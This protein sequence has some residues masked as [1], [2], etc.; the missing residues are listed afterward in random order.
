MGMIF[1]ILGAIPLAHAG[2]SIGLP[3][4]PISNGWSVLLAAFALILALKIRQWPPLI[5]KT[6]RSMAMLFLLL[7]MGWLLGDPIR[8]WLLLAIVIGFGWGLRKLIADVF[9]SGLLKL[10]HRPQTV[11]SGADFLGSI[12]SVKWR[13]VSL[14][15]EN[16]IPLDVP[17]RLMFTTAVTFLSSGNCPTKIRVFIPKAVRFQD[18]ID[19]IDKRLPAI[20][21]L[22]E[23]KASYEIDQT[24]P[25]I[26]SIR[27]N[28]LR[29]DDKERVR[30]SI[31][32]ALLSQEMRL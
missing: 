13:S 18:A 22:R 23:T 16:G 21:W 17:S 28:L 19:C 15:Q 4:W 6:M 9:A 30:K 29:F 24:N 10:N 8:N 5:Q 7:G 32:E 20:P 1:F 25:N 27:L 2:Q 26:L 14:I 12:V 31:S 11:V 3:S